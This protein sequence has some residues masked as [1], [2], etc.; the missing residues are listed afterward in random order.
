MEIEFKD[1]SN[2]YDGKNPKSFNPVEKLPYVI[3]NPDKNFNM[4]RTEQS[5][6]YS[7]GMVAYRTL[8]KKILNQIKS[9]E[10]GRGPSSKE[11]KTVEYLEGFNLPCVNLMQSLLLSAANSLE[12]KNE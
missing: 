5:D 8:F 3:V 9:S 10:I 1:F 7:F 2:S 6:V 12:K 11:L 4:N